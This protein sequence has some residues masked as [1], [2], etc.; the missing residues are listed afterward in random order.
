[1]PRNN[2]LLYLERVITK[3]ELDK[4]FNKTFK[5]NILQQTKNWLKNTFKNIFNQ[6]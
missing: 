4:K 3:E 6:H 2:L 5:P 1:M